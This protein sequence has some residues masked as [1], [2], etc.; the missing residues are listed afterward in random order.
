M[1]IWLDTT[2]LRESDCTADEASCMRESNPPD[3]RNENEEVLLS[4]RIA[5]RPPGYLTQEE[6][7]ALLARR[8]VCVHT[9]YVQAHAHGRWL[10]CNP[11]NEGNVAVLDAE[12]YDLLTSFHAPRS[13]F[14]VIEDLTGEQTASMISL[15]ARLG[16]LV[17]PDQPAPSFE[18]GERNHTLSAWIHVTNAC[19]LRCTYCYVDKTT[20][21][22]AEDTSKR[23]VDAIIRSALAFGYQHISLTYAGGEAMLQFPQVVATH[24]YAVEQARAH[25]LRVTG[26][27]ISNGSILTITMIEQLKRRHLGITISLDG[28]GEAHDGQRRFANGQGSFRLVERTISRLLAQEVV[29]HISITVTQRNLPDL[30]RLLEFI[31]AR[32]LPFGLNYYREN[33][34]ATNIEDLQFTAEQMIQ[35]MRAA[36]A[37]IEDHL[38]RRP[39]LGALL[40]KASVRSLHQYACGMGRHYMVV[41]QRGG[42]ARCQ[43]DL[44]NTVTTI[45]A[46]NPLQA[47]RGYRQGVQAVPV[48]EKEGCRTCE[49]RYWCSGGCPM[50]TYRLTGRSD[51]KS[52]NCSIYKALFPQAL[53][54]EALRLLKYEQPLA[55]TRVI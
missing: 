30:P 18:Q 22:M 41:D 14:E 36:F 35:G 12:A 39:L 32:D 50:L 43:V 55:L 27:I 33:D 11:T 26:G 1:N 2:L 21:H 6:R 4:G 25:G 38:P 29:P 19:N 34:H 16:F 20:E 8:F 5:F 31:L 24:D 28:L 42:I 37:Y 49:W 10:V 52:P 44:K 7:L 17:N 53:R 46:A 3:C 13:V 40:D 48:D 15:F 47:V 54:L 45:H 23:A 9:L 51:I